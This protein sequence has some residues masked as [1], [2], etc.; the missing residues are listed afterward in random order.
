[1][2]NRIKLLLLL[3]LTSQVLFGQKTYNG[4]FNT[5][6]LRGTAIY[7]Y[8]EDSNGSRIFSG[9]FKF[10]TPNKSVNITGNYKNNLKHG[11]WNISFNNYIDSWRQCIIDANVSGNYNNGNLEGNWTLSRKIYNNY[12]KELWFEE[13]STV[14]IK[15]GHLVGSFLYE[16]DIKRPS[17]TRKPMEGKNI[18][19]GNFDG[20]G[21]IDGEWKVDYYENGILFSQTKIYKN[22]MLI[23]VKN[24]NNS[25]G[26]ITIIYDNTE[27]YNK[28]FANYDSKENSAKIDNR[29]YCLVEG[30]DMQSHGYSIK[31]STS[32]WLNDTYPLYDYTAYQSEVER[33][34]NNAKAI[35]FERKIVI[36]EKR[37]KMIA[38]KEAAEREE[39]K[40]Q[41]A[42][43][44]R[45]TE[46]QIGNMRF[47]IRTTHEQIA[48]LYV[49]M[50][51][52]YD[53]LKSYGN[54][55]VA[56][57]PTL[58]SA[59]FSVYSKYFNYMN[60]V[61]HYPDNGDTQLLSDIISMQ[62][63]MI[64]WINEDTTEIEKQIK[65]ITDPEE[66]LKILK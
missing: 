18:I 45:E 29:Y 5:A 17:D 13:S 63:N 11:L 28:F 65:G 37:E 3:I 62:N 64:K 10:Y 7:D 51:A 52:Y 57:K 4:D 55:D 2:K 59:Y 22:G 9:T 56:K 32:I 12:N 25:T 40:Y 36:D 58:F 27:L 23:T 50:A 46:K 66:L 35:Y 49:K 19:K 8:T 16:I 21:Y 48:K 30:N 26:D 33:G 14:T 42:A 34:N 53:L 41:E 38:E 39:R 54:T 31:E 47:T 44:Q 1:M 61:S 6:H 43:K 24:K 15:D 60:N 20:N